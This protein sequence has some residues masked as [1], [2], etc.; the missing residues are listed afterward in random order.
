MLFLPLIHQCL[1]LLGRSKDLI[2][3]LSEFSEQLLSL[4]P[5]YNGA[6]IRERMK[7]MEDNLYSASTESNEMILAAVNHHKKVVQDS[8]AV[9]DK[10]L[11]RNEEEL[12][13]IKKTKKKVS[14]DF[15][16]VS[17]PHLSLYAHRNHFN[18]PILCIQNAYYVTLLIH[19]LSYYTNMYHITFVL[20]Y[21]RIKVRKSVNS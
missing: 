19:I 2:K 6:C 21:N 8:L 17:Y 16:Q 11:G 7:S 15:K 1:K 9:L 12:K 10:W 20:L 18:N 4:E 5:H 3:S 13:N 14:N